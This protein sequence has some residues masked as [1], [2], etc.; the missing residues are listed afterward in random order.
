MKSAWRVL[1]RPLIL[2]TKEKS[3]GKFPTW[4]LPIIRLED[5]QNL[6]Q[7]ISFVNVNCLIINMEHFSFRFILVEISYF[8][9][10]VWDFLFC[11]FMVLLTNKQW[12]FLKLFSNCLNK[13]LDIAKT[14][15][16]A[17]FKIFHSY[18]NSDIVQV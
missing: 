6:R 13:V 16:S 4:G 3:E 5:Q 17:L 9:S 18:Q 10:I 7:V 2:L 1:D 11:F 15:S 14:T 12:V 8:L